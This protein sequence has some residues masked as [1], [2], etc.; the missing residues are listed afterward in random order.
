MS[1]P[2]A[3]RLARI[4]SALLRYPALEGWT[5]PAPHPLPERPQPAQLSAR[6]MLEEAEWH[7]AEAARLRAGVQK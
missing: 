5:P 4:D 6:L 7:E 3:A 2:G 1:Q